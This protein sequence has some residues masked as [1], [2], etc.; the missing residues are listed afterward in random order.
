[1]KLVS[2]V[3][4]FTLLFI[5]SA[6]FAQTGT[7]GLKAVAT[8]DPKGSVTS[9]VWKQ[10]TG[11]AFQAFTPV[12]DSVTVVSAI[13]GDYQVT[14]TVTDNQGNT[15]TQTS[16]LRF[17]AYVNAKPTMIINPGSTINNP[18]IIQIK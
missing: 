9:Y 4:L 16:Y 5:T 14:C 18:I 11:P 3:T 2:F 10:T 12:N 15:V 6:T 1:M 13:A 8:V 17:T 7:K